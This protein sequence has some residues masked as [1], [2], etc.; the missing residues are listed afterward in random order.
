MPPPAPAGSLLRPDLRIFQVFGANTDVGKTIWTT[1]LCRASNCDTET[2][3]WYLKP[4][5][6]GPADAADAKCKQRYVW[7]SRFNAGAVLTMSRR[8]E[9][10][11]HSENVSLSKFPS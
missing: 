10:P 11:D 7:P 3:T 2:T 9:L 6:T 4:V 1:I 8:K 5:S